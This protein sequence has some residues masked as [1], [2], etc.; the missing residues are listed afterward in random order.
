MRYGGPA[1]N[2][3][4]RSLALGIER[5]PLRGFLY[6][7]SEGPSCGPATLMNPQD[8]RQN[9]NEACEVAEAFSLRLGW[10][11][12]VPPHPGPLPQGEGNGHPASFSSRASLSL[13]PCAPRFNAETP[14]RPSAFDSPCSRGRFS[15][16]PRER[17]GVRGKSLVP[18][19]QIHAQPFDASLHPV[20]PLSKGRGNAPPKCG[21]PCGPVS[22]PRER[23]STAGGIVRLDP[24]GG[25]TDQLR[26][27]PQFE[28]L[29][30][31]TAV[32]IHRLGTH[33]ELAGNFMVS[34]AAPDEL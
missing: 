34:L 2:W 20:P 12:L 25:V 21:V 19:D 31:V 3:E 33:V 8:R 13:A 10:L 15:L 16:S 1:H 27:T 5:S 29:L 14:A 24:A 9:D 4:I 18:V 28:L 7:P 30:D 17:A 22:T 6:A 26:R 11:R 23:G 32:G